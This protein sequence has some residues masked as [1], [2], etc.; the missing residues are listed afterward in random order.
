[1]IAQVSPSRHRTVSPRA[2]AQPVSAN[3]R[4]GRLRA[5]VS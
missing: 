5:A 3:G 2:V 4:L 1:M